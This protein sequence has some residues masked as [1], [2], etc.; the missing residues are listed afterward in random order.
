MVMLCLTVPIIS[1]ILDEE[2]VRKTGFVDQMPVLDQLGFPVSF[3]DGFAVGQ[4]LSDLLQVFVLFDSMA[5][6]ASGCSRNSLAMSPTPK[7]RVQILAKVQSFQGSGSTSKTMQ[8]F[9]QTLQIHE[10]HPGEYS[11]M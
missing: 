11:R 4:L 10:L 9:S 8:N 7:V 6:G 2:V 3:H 1:G 5:G